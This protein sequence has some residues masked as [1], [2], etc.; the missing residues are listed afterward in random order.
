[1]RLFSLPSI[2]AVVVLAGS[3]LVVLAEAEAARSAPRLRGEAA[4]DHRLLSAMHLR[5]R[6]RLEESLGVLRGLLTE[7]PRHFSAH[8]LYMEI[9]GVSRRNGGL[10]EAEY[11]HYL[12]QDPHDGQRMALHAAALLTLELTTRGPLKATS[13]REIE[14]TLAAA[15]ADPKAEAWAHFLSYELDRLRRR[16][17]AALAHLERA[18]ELKPN[19]PDF[20]SEFIPLLVRDGEFDKAASLCR[21]LLK[22]YPWRAWAC[23]SV[24]P[25]RAGDEAASEE[26]RDT[27]ID[28]L[29]RIESRWKLDSTT[30][31]GL[32]TL[33]SEL[34]DRRAVKRLRGLLVQL[35]GAWS[36]PSSRNPYLRALPGGE[37]DDASLALL[38]RLGEVAEANE[39]DPWALVEALRALEGS[40]PE[41][42]SVRSIYFRQLAYA[43]RHPDVLDRDG[44][45]AAVQQ[46]MEALPDDP[47]AMNEWAYMS[48]L[49]KVDLAQALET[50]DRALLLLLGEPFELLQLDPGEAFGEWEIG[51]AESVGAFIDTR[52]WLLY[53]LGRHQE[54]ERDLELASLL[55]GDGTVQGH[56]GRARYASG[57][58]GAAFHNLLR[59]LALGTEEQDEVHTL[60]RYLYDKLHV[61]PGGLDALVQETRR[62][63]GQDFTRAARDLFLAPP[64]GGEPGQPAGPEGRI[65]VPRTGPSPPDVG[66]EI[67]EAPGL[68]A[69]AGERGGGGA[70]PPGGR[71]RNSHPL[72]GQPAPDFTAQT[73]QGGE[74][75]LSSLLGQVVV[76]D[77]WATWCAPCVDSLPALVELHEA[78]GGRAARLL[79]V[80]LDDSESEVLSFW[81]QHEVGLEAVLGDSDLAADYGVSGIPAT[82]VIDPEGRVHSYE[83]G[84]ADDL[85]RRVETEVRELLEG[86]AS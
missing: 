82:I 40:L 20:K 36:P 86:D 49:D 34:E 80:A 24:F 26:L 11:R 62:Q 65:L 23:A 45:R 6:G 18:L 30:L 50:I 73:V 46:A 42:Q 25:R 35:D 2:L 70:A 28:D 22:T 60:A 41:T 67:F 83:S 27:I 74:V 31:L 77:F 44:S 72:V 55:T 84:Y 15:E 59:A 79:I 33:Y 16:P 4:A 10:V 47:H 53:Q 69:P 17:V 64:T 75:T 32:E 51:R 7:H 12:S 54:A 71:S 68:R 61:V 29:T 19:Q 48:A 21:D 39:E 81:K 37:L 13:L 43:L 58:D 38:E 9:A 3:L 76:L 85:V 66:H 63:I 56:L 57:N 52:G 1:M 5:D 78:L 14:R 8:R